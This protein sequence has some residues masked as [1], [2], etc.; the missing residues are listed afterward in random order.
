MQGTQ[1]QGGASGV[2]GQPGQGIPGQVAGQVAGDPRGMPAQ[3][4][5]DPRGLPGQLPP[6]GLQGSGQ[7]ARGMQGQGQGLMGPG[8]GG[9]DPRGMQGQGPQGLM[10]PG[11]GLPSQ[12][13]GPQAGGGMTTSQAYNTSGSMGFSSGKPYLWLHLIARSP[14]YHLRTRFKLPPTLRFVGKVL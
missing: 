10:G 12:G 7:E 3:G 4:G 9:S 2:T 1:L 8:Q 6:Q 14:P 13:L 11:Q 5:Q